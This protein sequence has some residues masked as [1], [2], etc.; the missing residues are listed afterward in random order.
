MNYTMLTCQDLAT[1]QVLDIVKNGSIYNVELTNSESFISIG[2]TTLDE[3]KQKYIKLV[4]CFVNGYYTFEQR[5][6]IL[7]ENIKNERV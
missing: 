5:V 7:K 4:D 2:F 6:E 1:G 3:A